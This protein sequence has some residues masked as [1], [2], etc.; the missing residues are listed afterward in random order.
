MVRLIGESD[1]VVPN[2]GM[3]VL[4]AI[5][6]LAM[7]VLMVIKLDTQKGGK[8]SGEWSSKKS[9]AKR[10][11]VVLGIGEDEVHEEGEEENLQAK[12]RKSQAKKE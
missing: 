9:V 12:W 11:R 6:L 1:L 2:Q 10:K 4:M 8:G 7:V 3:S 5:V